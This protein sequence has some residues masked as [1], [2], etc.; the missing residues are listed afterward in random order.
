MELQ[1]SVEDEQ[2]VKR[3]RG[4]FDRRDS[5]SNI[6]IISFEWHSILVTCVI[7]YP[8]EQSC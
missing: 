5:Q 7:D 1:V 3:P 8:L 4:I 6:A 2:N